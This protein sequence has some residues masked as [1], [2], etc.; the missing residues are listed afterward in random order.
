[1]SHVACDHG[2]GGDAPHMPPY[3]LRAMGVRIPY[4]AG[5]MGLHVC[6]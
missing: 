6:A 3:M 4:C 5:L 2:G 1:M